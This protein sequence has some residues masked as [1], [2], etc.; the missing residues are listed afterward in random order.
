MEDVY[1]AAFLAR[2]AH[3]V[4]DT[5]IVALVLAGRLTVNS[6]GDLAAVD[7]TRRHPVDAAVLDAFGPSRHRS[8][9][10]VHV[11]LVE[12]PRIL[13]VGRQ[14][15]SDGLLT[16]FGAGGARRGELPGVVR[17][18]GEG[19]RALA[20]AR[21][22]RSEVD[23][24]WRVAFDGRAAMRDASLRAAIFEP[25]GR[26]RALPSDRSI[27]AQRQRNSVIRYESNDLG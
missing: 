15:R 14:L 24:A 22:Q 16:R 17:L 27:A 8:V 9:E 3:R 7:P 4:I 10:T 23:D 21:E 25:P 2:G 1:E 19:R 5:A 18:T 13:G 20:D 11:R 12:D 26:E 6:A